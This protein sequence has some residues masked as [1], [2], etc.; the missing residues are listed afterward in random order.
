MTLFA[1]ATR[2]RT[3]WLLFSSAAVVCGQTAYRPFTV[4]MPGN[5]H[6]P[7]RTERARALMTEGWSLTA[8]QAK[9]LEVDLSRDPE[10]LGV[11][12]P[13]DE[14]LLSERAHRA[15][16]STRPLVD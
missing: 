16:G 13:V 11:R 1:I 10:N 3:A 6:R 7:E 2:T 14:L 8:A 15:E 4:S 12:A 9:Q 5:S